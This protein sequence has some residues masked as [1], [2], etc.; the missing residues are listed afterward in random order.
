M[1]ILSSA[2]KLFLLIFSIDFIALLFLTSYK[3]QMAGL[4]L[5]TGLR[6]NWL[7]PR[8]FISHDRVSMWKSVAQDHSRS[9][10]DAEACAAVSWTLWN[11]EVISPT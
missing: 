1:Q 7:A 4:F 2:V 10:L 6:G 11:L 5:C 3:T 9:Q 8:V